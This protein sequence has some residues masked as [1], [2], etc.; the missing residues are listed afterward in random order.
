MPDHKSLELVQAVGH[1]FLVRKEDLR[2]QFLPLLRDP[3][4]FRIRLWE[5]GV[6]SLLLYHLVKSDQIVSFASGG[7]MVC[8]VYPEIELEARP[9]GVGSC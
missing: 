7:Q 6:D 3:S 5:Y 4:D 9:V 2:V 1:S 8:T